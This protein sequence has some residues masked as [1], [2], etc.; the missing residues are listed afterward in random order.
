MPSTLSPNMSLILPTVG[1]EPGP[2]WALDLNNSLSII[3]QHTHAP[4][5]GSQISPAGLNINIDLPF[6][7]NN[8]ISLRSVRFDPQL[9]PIA[10]GSDIGCLYVSGQDLYYNDVSGTQIQITA[11]GA[12]AGTPG[13]I[14]NLIAP[15]AVTYVPANQSF[16]FESNQTNSTPAAIDCGPLYI[17]NIAPSSNYIQLSANPVLPANYSLTL[18]SALPVSSKIVRLDSLGNLSATLDVDNSTIE[19]SSNNLQVKDLGITTAKLNDQAVTTIKIAD[20][21]VTTVKILDQNVTPVKRSP[22]AFNIA[23]VNTS[24]FISPSELTFVSTSITTTAANKVAFATFYPIGATGYY[25][26]GGNAYVVIRV[27][28]P[29]LGS[30]ILGT[31]WPGVSGGA[32]GG[33]SGSMPIN[34]LVQ[35]PQAGTYTFWCA[36][37][38]TGG[39]H[40]GYAIACRLAVAEL[41]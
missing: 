34:G 26:G 10:L 29:G 36:M 27:S 25:G 15:A 41:G 11:L 16:V 35:L 32:P 39:G 5:S 13:S 23:D 22:G 6:N 12:V 40:T 14:G 9:A 20:N 3:D 24:F 17:R 31:T 2:N 30:T 7:G 33:I 28:G 8:A 18:P 38:S 21:N 1:Q 4:G 19:I 37:A